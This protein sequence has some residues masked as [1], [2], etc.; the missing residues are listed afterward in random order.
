[1]GAKKLM[2]EIWKRPNGR[3]EAVLP[4]VPEDDLDAFLLNYR[5]FQQ[6]NDRISIYRMS[7]AIAALPL[8]TET[9]TEFEKI[10]RE[11]N[12]YLD[13]APEM[14]ILGQPVTRRDLLDGFLYGVYAHLDERKGIDASYWERMLKKDHVDLLFVTTLEGVVDF[15]RKFEKVMRDVDLELKIAE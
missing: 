7:E 10:R 12:E 3:F 11:L 4:T 2:V 13:A 14:Q 15:L 6:N 1:M 5:L 9:K 8:T